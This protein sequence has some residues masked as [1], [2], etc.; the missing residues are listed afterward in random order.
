M[1]LMLES[2]GKVGICYHGVSDEVLARQIQCPFVLYG[3]DSA[4]EIAHPRNVGTFPRLLSTFVR[5]RDVIRLSEAVE[6]LTRE[7]ARLLGLTDRGQLKPVF[8][9]TPW[10]WITRD[11]PTAPRRWTLGIPAGVDYVVV[12]GQMALEDGELVEGSPG[13]V[14][15]RVE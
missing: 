1:A 4:R 12:N 13:R 10:S 3:S 15:R 7:P 14:L 11:W 5:D 2:K 8:G 9:G 6:K